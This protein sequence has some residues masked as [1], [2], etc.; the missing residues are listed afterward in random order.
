MII[1]IIIIKLKNR[2][3]LQRK[4]D[5]FSVVLEMTVSTNRKS[6]RISMNFSKLMNNNLNI[7]QGGF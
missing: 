5:V 4:K 3:F 7:K 1:F 2:I 6:K